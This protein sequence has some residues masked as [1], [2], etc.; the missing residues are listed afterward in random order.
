MHDTFSVRINSFQNYIQCRVIGAITS[1][2][3]KLYKETLQKAILQ[4]QVSQRFFVIDY[5]EVEMFSSTCIN[6]ILSL[7]EIINN[8]EC[9]LVIV[10]SNKEVNELLDDTGFSRIFPVYRSMQSFLNEKNI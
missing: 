5:S 1:S 6:V 3:F 7:K 4:K 10:S 9:E 2:S 8:N